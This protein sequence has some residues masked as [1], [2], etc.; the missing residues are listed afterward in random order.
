[1]EKS[2]DNDGINIYMVLNEWLL[3][4]D[5][6]EIGMLKN[7]HIGHLADLEIRSVNGNYIP[8]YNVS[9]FVEFQS[10][11]NMGC[12][13]SEVIINL[14]KDILSALSGLESYLLVVNSI[15]L[16]ENFIFYDTGNKSFCFIYIP[17]YKQ[18]IRSQIRKLLEDCMRIMRH[19]NEYETSFVYD[20]Y[21][22]CAENNFDMRLVE[23]YIEKHI[24]GRQEDVIETGVYEE[25]P[26]EDEEDT[27]SNVKTKLSCDNNIYLIYKVILAVSAIVTLFFGAGNVCLQYYKMKQIYNIRPIIGVLLLLVIEIFIY[28]EIARNKEKSEKNNLQNQE[29]SDMTLCLKEDDKILCGYSYVLVPYGNTVNEPIYVNKN[30]LVIGRGNAAGYCL[31]NPSVSRNHAKIYELNNQ[32]VIEDLNST[33]G[34]YVNNYPVKAGYPAVIFPGDIIRFGSEEYRMEFI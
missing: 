27:F 4:K 8:Y 34:T 5:N 22:K 14:I 11:I 9:G 23:R 12:L 33:N 19:E 3:Q 15:I 21:E 29:D 6:Y 20:L 17:G 25:V 24:A 2:Y 32:L 13:E 31:K 18:D 16:E 1:M 30:I 10:L 28:F 26:E 7:N